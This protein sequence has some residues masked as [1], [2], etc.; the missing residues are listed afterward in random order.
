[1]ETVLPIFVVPALLIGTIHFY[2]FIPLLLTLILP[3]SVVNLMF[4]ICHPFNNQGREPCLCDF[5][6]KAFNI[7][8]YS[9]IYK[10]IFF[11]R[12][13]MVE[14]NKF[15]ILMYGG[16]WPSF[17]VTVI[18]ESKTPVSIFLQIYSTIWMEFSFLPQLAGLLKLMLIFLFCFVLFFAQV[19][20]KGE[21]F[22][23]AG[24]R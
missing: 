19:I 21:N 7:G 24:R 11:K 10:P 12:E 17:K 18:W 14:T 3:V 20:I 16:S 9:D 1:M 15:Y 4:I 23:A 8:L 2:H 5:V 13:M 22:V 6:K